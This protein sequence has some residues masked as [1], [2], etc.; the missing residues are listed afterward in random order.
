MTR[1]FLLGA[2][3]AALAFLGSAVPAAAAGQ[4]SPLEVTYY[5]LPG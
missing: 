5:Y 3:L 2:S 1:R 4:A